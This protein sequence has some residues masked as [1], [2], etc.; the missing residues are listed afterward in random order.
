MCISDAKIK[1]KLKKNINKFIKLQ[2][3]YLKSIT[4]YCIEATYQPELGSQIEVT[5]ATQMMTQKSK[6][7]KF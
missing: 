3:Q 7:Y 4:L 5:N 6:L 2:C 1:I